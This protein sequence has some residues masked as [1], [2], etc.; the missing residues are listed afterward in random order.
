MPASDLL[1]RGYQDQWVLF[2]RSSQNPAS[3]TRLAQKGV[4]EQG[5]A[6]I[7]GALWRFALQQEVHGA[8]AYCLQLVAPSS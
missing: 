7:C 3:A 4:L 6:S 5:C 8:N 1:R 2:L